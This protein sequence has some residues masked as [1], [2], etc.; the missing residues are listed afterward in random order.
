LIL[1]L[2]RFTHLNIITRGQTSLVR[3]LPGK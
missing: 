3:K 2:I 1:I